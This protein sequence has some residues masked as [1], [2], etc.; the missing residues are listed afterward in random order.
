MIPLTSFLWACSL[1]EKNRM[2]L[3][4]CNVFPCVAL[5]LLVYDR[6]TDVNRTNRLT[7]GDTANIQ[8]ALPRWFLLTFSPSHL[9]IGMDWVIGSLKTSFGEQRGYFFLTFQL[10]WLWCHVFTLCELSWFSTILHFL[11]LCQNLCVLSLK[12][13]FVLFVFSPMPFLK[14][15]A[16]MEIAK[17]LVESSKTAKRWGAFAQPDSY[18][19][20]QGNY[21]SLE[22]SRSCWFPKT[23]ELFLSR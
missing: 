12:A 15:D 22:G 13:I 4:S 23:T 21:W 18:C 9:E 3:G 1:D 20:R 10:F 2:T 16:Y 17:M 11:V 14:A 5:F 6:W 19:V 8:G 7:Y